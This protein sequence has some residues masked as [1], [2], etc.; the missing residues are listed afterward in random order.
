MLCVVVGGT[1]F[2]QSSL[3]TDVNRVDLKRPHHW[4]G[5]APERTASRLGL[6]T[7]T[8]PTP[9]NPRMF[10]FSSY[11]GP[12]VNLS[13]SDPAVLRVMRVMRIGS[14]RYSLSVFLRRSHRLDVYTLF[15]RTAQIWWSKIE[16]SWIL[17]VHNL[18]HATVRIAT[19]LPSMHRATVM[20]VPRWFH[21]QQLEHL[22]G[23]VD[24]RQGW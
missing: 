24:G 23:P 20:Q 2:V 18:T 15:F 14:L 13:Y 21:R 5:T 9:I 10:G 4:Q 11:L 16:T 8:T 3:E 12:V 6:V 22:H 1:T 17:V 7:T 19:L